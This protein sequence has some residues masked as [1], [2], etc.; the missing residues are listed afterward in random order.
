MTRQLTASST[1]D[2]LKKEAKR[3]LKALRAN[4]EQAR[5]RLER[6]YPNAPAEPGLRD[7]QHALALEHGLAGWTALKQQLTGKQ[8][9]E[10]PQ[11]D[12]VAW[13]IE[14]ACPDH[15]VRGGPAHVRAVH[16]AIRVLKRFPEVAHDSFYTAIV[17]GDLEEVER[18]LAEHPEAANEKGGPKGW[19][20]LLYLCFTRLPLAASNDNAMAIARVL[21]DRG[22]NPNMYFMAGDSRY[23]PLVGVIGEGE[24]DRPPHPHRDALARLLL[25]GGAEPYDIQVVYN[26]HFHGKILWFLKLIYPYAVKLGRQSDWDDPAWSMLDMGG[27]GNGARWHLG[28]AIGNNDLELAEWVLTHGAS[29][30]AAPPRDARMSKRTLHE[31]ALRMWH[32]EMAELLVRHGAIPSAFVPTDADLFAAACFRLDQESAKAVVAKHPEYLTSTEVM[33]AAAKRDRADVVAFLLDLGMSPDVE[34]RQK[35][36]PL[37]MA[38]YA[39]SLRVAQLLIERGAE[40]D[41]VESNWSNTPLGGAVYGQH[42]LMIELLSRSSRDVWELTYIGN[43]ERLREVLSTRPELAKIVTSGHTPLMWLPPDDEARAMEIAR[44]LLAHG[45]DPSLRN[46]EG[47]T[48]ADRAYRLGMFDVAELLRVDVSAAPAAPAPAGPTLEQFESLAEDVVEVYN[49]GD[50]D[51]LRRLQAYLGQVFTLDEFRARLRRQMSAVAELEPGYDLPLDKAKF[52]VAR[53]HGFESWADLVERSG[54]AGFGL[55]GNLKG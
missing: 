52:F 38:A 35:Q 13:F 36:R 17:C 51:A 45:A 42:A 41:P 27:Y 12:R 34:D 30:D 44:L 22:A 47:Q 26:I 29:P 53:G 3:W 5:A 19:E 23:T 16:T 2:N 43:V 31:E 48:A 37:H 21:L 8:L 14:N 25:E 32:T 40:I 24:E 1:L 10:E 33:F 11:I 50:T 46:T 54:V 28:I 6:I 9:A 39:D 49:S 15:H 4:D 20:P 7:I 55:S 18:V